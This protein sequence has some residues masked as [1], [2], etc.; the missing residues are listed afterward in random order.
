MVNIRPWCTIFAWACVTLRDRRC[1]KWVPMRRRP[2]LESTGASAVNFMMRYCLFLLVVAVCEAGRI[3]RGVVHE[4]NFQ[5]IYH[6][7]GATSYQNVQVDSHDSIIVPTNYGDQAELLDLKDHEYHQPIIPIV[8]THNDVDHIDISD[9]APY[10][11][12]TIADV[13]LKSD[14]LS[15]YLDHDDDKHDFDFHLRK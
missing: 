9:S 4:P 12:F 8:E 2:Q 10:E 13:K 3:P 14:V 11:E 1:I 6:G 7:H 15:H 5:A